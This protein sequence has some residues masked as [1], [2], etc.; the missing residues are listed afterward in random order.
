MASGRNHISGLTCRAWQHLPNADLGAEYPGQ[1]KEQVQR[2][3]GRNKPEY[4][5]VRWREAWVA[6]G[7]HGARWG[8]VLLTKFPSAW[9]ERAVS[10]CC[11]E[12]EL[13][14][15]PF[16]SCASSLTCL[17]SLVISVALCSADTCFVQLGAPGMEVADRQIQR[18]AWTGHRFGD[19]PFC[20]G[21][22][23]VATVRPRV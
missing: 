12:A 11:A 8:L 6:R 14:T 5:R 15:F 20:C 1:S 22:W 23:G 16:S 21:S 18:S 2:P 3:W 7:G 17:T 9:Q 19:E 4:L 13:I 10:T